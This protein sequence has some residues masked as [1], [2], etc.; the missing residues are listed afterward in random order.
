MRHPDRVQAAR[1][2]RVVRQRGYD[3]HSHVRTPA[4]RR[5]SCRIIASAGAATMIIGVRGDP[6]HGRHRRRAETSRWVAG[7][8]TPGRMSTLRETSG[9]ASAVRPRRA[10]RPHQSFG[11]RSRALDWNDV[12]PM[13]VLLWLGG[14]GS[15]GPWRMVLTHEH[16]GATRRYERNETIVLI[17][18]V[19]RRRALSGRL[20]AVPGR[21]FFQ[22]TN[23]PKNRGGSA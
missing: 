5:D 21:P 11:A 12:E 7:L 6:V 19:G 14:C 23:G 4:R 9:Q 17:A 13:G 1:I 3:G 8:P 2:G 22:V 15:A 10:F 18:S 20:L 16:P